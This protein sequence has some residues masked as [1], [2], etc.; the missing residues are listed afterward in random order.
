MF[1][2]M[3]WCR[4]DRAYKVG[5]V[6]IAPYHGRLEG[7]DDVM[8]RHLARVMGTYRDIEGR[9]VEHAAVVLYADK[10]FGVERVCSSG[11][12]APTTFTWQ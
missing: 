1:P 11:S 2:I 8:Q 7:V 6:T 12:S 10:P 5:D 3:P 9:P 4:I